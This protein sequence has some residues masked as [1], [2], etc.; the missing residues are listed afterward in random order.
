MR[1]STE[2]ACCESRQESGTDQ[3]IHRRLTHLSKYGIRRMPLASHCNKQTEK[4]VRQ[5]WCGLR[6]LKKNTRQWATAANTHLGGQEAPKVPRPVRDKSEAEPV[7]L[8]RV[9]RG[10]AH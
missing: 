9:P 8:R 1:R 3:N 7:A 4:G 5:L 6:N 2:A 10:R